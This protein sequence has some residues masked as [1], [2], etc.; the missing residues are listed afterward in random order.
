M[1]GHTSCDKLKVKDFRRT[2]PQ[3]SIDSMVHWPKG[4]FP[5]QN[6]VRGRREFKFAPCLLEGRPKP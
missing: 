1:R 5:Q 6:G 4:S 2:M 3:F